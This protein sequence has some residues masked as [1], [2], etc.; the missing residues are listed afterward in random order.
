MICLAIVTHY[1]VQIDES[2]EAFNP[3]F[4][5][6][7]FYF[8]RKYRHKFVKKYDGRLMDDEVFLQRAKKNYE[9]KIRVFF[10]VRKE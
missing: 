2:F 7:S 9:K 8:A 1:F 6:P 5:L 10:V 3:I 4:S